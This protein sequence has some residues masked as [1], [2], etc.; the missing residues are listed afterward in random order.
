MEPDSATVDPGPNVLMSGLSADELRR[1][2]RWGL[3]RFEA[4]VGAI[5]GARFLGLGFPAVAHEAIGMGPIVLPLVIAGVGILCSIAGT[6]FVRTKEGGNPQVA[7]DIGVFGAAGVMAAAT[8]GLAK[9]LLDRLELFV[10]IVL[11]LRLLHLALDAAANP[12]LHLEHA[13]FAFHQ[14]VDFLQAFIDADDFK[15]VLL[16]RDAQRH[17]RGHGI[18]E[19]AGILDLIK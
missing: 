2:L 10:E 7:L 13:D 18:G 11:A 14:R 8:F 15:K 5:V 6:F 3:C 1:R 12:L 17:V 16:L 9:L 4:Y 19:L